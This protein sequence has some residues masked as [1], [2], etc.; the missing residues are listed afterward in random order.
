MRPS[1]PTLTGGSLA[2]SFGIDDAR[3]S[4]PLPQPGK[5]ATI[6]K[7]KRKVT[8]MNSPGPGA[9]APDPFELERFCVAQ[10]ECY[11]LALTEIRR[12]RKSGHWM[13]FIFPQLA[14]LGSS[15]IARLYAIRSIDEARAFLDHPVL[16]NRLRACV[17][18]LQDLPI[19]TAEEVFGIVDALKLRSSLTLFGEAGGGALFSAALSRWFSGAPDPNTLRLLLERRVVE[20]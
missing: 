7:C 8:F 9:G 17:E 13:W 18:T 4:A 11:D 1:F 14:G 12:G 20:R 2:G 15:P 5:R 10:A 3:R 6:V 16:G 19:S